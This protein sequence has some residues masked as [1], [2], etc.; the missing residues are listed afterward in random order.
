MAQTSFRSSVKNAM[1]CHN[2]AASASLPVKVQICRLLQ[3]PAD[4]PVFL[5]QGCDLVFSLPQGQGHDLS[6]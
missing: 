2:T 6:S 4:N 1:N 5:P 3:S